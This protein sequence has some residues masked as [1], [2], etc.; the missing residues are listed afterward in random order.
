[1]RSRIAPRAS[2]RHFSSTVWRR[3]AGVRRQHF[4]GGCGGPRAHA[5]LQHARRAQGGEALGRQ[6]WRGSSGRARACSPGAAKRA[7]WRGYFFHQVTARP[8]GGRITASAM[9]PTG[10]AFAQ[11]RQPDVKRPSAPVSA[12]IFGALVTTHR[13]SASLRCSPRRSGS[14]AILRPW[15]PHDFVVR[16]GAFFSMLGNTKSPVG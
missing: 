5:L 6:A 9:R 3:A 10:D 11:P 12:E 8:R 16:H 2:L 13:S 14:A 15:T 4:R 1:M 7:H